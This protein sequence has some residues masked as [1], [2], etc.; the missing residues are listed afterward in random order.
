MTTAYLKASRAVG[1]RL[2]RS[3]PQTVKD[4]GKVIEVSFSGCDL[5]I[6]ENLWHLSHFL[7]KAIASVLKVGQKY[8]CRIALWA[9][10][11]S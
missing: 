7:A 6:L 3:I 8:P 1:S 10:D 11:C 2:I 5:G 9:S 4:H